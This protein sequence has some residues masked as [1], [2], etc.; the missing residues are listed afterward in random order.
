MSSWILDI[1]DHL[2]KRIENYG[3]QLSF[4]PYT[5]NLSHKECLKIYD[6]FLE[7]IQKIRENFSEKF[8]KKM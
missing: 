5:G 2:K 6:S 4:C 3:I 1:A 7:E 8:K